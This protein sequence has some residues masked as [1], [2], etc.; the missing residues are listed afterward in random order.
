MIHMLL[1]VAGFIHSM[2]AKTTRAGVCPP[3]EVVPK[4]YCNSTD[5]RSDCSEVGNDYDCQTEGYKCC[6]GVCGSLLCQTSLTDDRPGCPPINPNLRCRIYNQQCNTDNE[7][8]QGKQCCYQPSCG[9]SCFSLDPACPSYRKDVICKRFDK[10]C[11]I[12]DDCKEGDICC[13]IEC[14]TEC[15]T[16]Y[17]SPYVECPKVNC[18][19]K[20][21]FGSVIDSGGCHTC[22]CKPSP[23]LPPQCPRPPPDAC[24]EIEY[25]IIDGIRCVWCYKVVPCKHKVCPEEP[26]DSKTCDDYTRDCKDDSSCTDGQKCCK[27]G[28]NYVCVDPA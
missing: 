5:V 22:A 25:K 6:P 9:T 3:P 4:D 17:R 20:C 13:S 7:C 14:G 10:Q 16:P 12:N 1:L 11:T 28:C 8:S 23:C 2:N 24:M 26:E 21:E 18:S 15:R 27:Q 19:N